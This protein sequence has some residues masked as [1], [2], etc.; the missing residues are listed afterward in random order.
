MNKTVIVNASLITPHGIEADTCLAF[1][2]GKII[3]V[4]DYPVDGAQVIDAKGKY[5]SAGFIDIHTHGA[6]G[7]D[8][9]DGTVQAIHGAAR[10]SAVHGA[11]TVYPTTVAASTEEV[12]HFIETYKKAKEQPHDGALL[13]GIHLEG[14]YFSHEQA[15]AQDPKYIV[16]PDPEEYSAIAE[17]AGEDLKRWSAAPELPGAL[18]FGDFLKKRG[19]LGA[20]AHSNAYT[21]QVLDAIFHGFTHI[22]HI[23]SGM[24]TVR[25]ENARRYGGVV[26]A[27]YLSDLITVEMICDGMHLPKE[28]LQLIIRIKGPENVCLVTDSMR[29]AGQDVSESILGSTENGQRVI[30]KEGVAWV[31]SMQ[32]FAGSV[33]TCDRLVRTAVELAGVSLRQAVMMM[34]ET[35]ARI[36]GIG[37]TKGRLVKGYDAD[38]VIFDKNVNIS[39]TIIGGKTVYNRNA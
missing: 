18:E 10:T 13:G 16:N 31:P 22:T 6:G 24:S 12:L 21:Q 5:V 36:M 34:T 32:S 4:G 27:A 23:Y 37:S 19:I 14:S 17:A 15:G 2:D 3:F 35:P 11:T 28:L 8:Y 29:A 26:E 1:E 20:V 38:L 9:M 33:A 7:F 25:R 39:R 30:I